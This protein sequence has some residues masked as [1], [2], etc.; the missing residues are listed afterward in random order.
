MNDETGSPQVQP[1]E[2]PTS[3]FPAQP[4]AGTA[5]VVVTEQSA[6]ETATQRKR[7][8]WLLV[9]VIL[10]FAL[11][12]AAGVYAYQQS[13]TRS[14]ARAQIDEA[15]TLIEDADVVVLEVDEAVRAEITA[16]VGEQAADLQER[17]PQAID[18]LGQ[19]AMLIDEATPDLA[20]EDVPRAEA[21]KD[22]A[23]ARAEMLGTVDPILEGN[24]RAA[25]ALQPALDAWSAVLEGETL[26]DQAIAEYNKLTTEGVTRSQTL[27]ADAVAKYGSAKQLF[28]TAATG[29]PEADFTAY[30]T[31][32]DG[33]IELLGISKQANDA[34]LAGDKAKANTL[35]TQYNAK[36]KELVALAAELPET[37][38]EVVASA[39]E[40]FA[41]EA[42]T[43]YFEA[44]QRATD[45][46]KVLNDLEG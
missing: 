35:S 6:D 46:D 22:S 37:P 9:A 28:S 43:E 41:G 18:D 27:T 20:D 15:T 36:D 11:A 7:R 45:A 13:Q 44:R 31:Y 26:A 38:A 4:P 30:V 21:L 2:E 29:F 32:V 19:A 14:A 25:A 12:G 17:V 24:I 3:G 39:Y 5:A 16:E 10:A 1:A 33:K 42:T 23:L 8:W 40:E 34:F